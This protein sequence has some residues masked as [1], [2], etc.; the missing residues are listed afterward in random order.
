MRKPNRKAL[1]R[2]LQAAV[3]LY[4]RLRDCA[5]QGGCE[6]ISCGK[7]YPFEDLDGGHFIPTTSSATRYDERNVNA[8]DRK[9]NRFLHGNLRNYY[10]GMKCKWGQKVI[11]E[12]QAQQYVT[13]KWSIPELRERL[14]YF[15]QKIAE[16]S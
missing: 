5:G 1:A 9:C 13:K 15:E 8:Q 3:N 6:C 14:E 11:D 16:L 2:K 10:E 7:W 4:A 12:L